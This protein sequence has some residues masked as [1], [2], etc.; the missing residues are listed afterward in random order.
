MLGIRFASHLIEGFL[1][2]VPVWEGLEVCHTFLAHACIDHTPSLHE[3]CLLKQ[4]R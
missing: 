4:P 1:E 3:A 2:H